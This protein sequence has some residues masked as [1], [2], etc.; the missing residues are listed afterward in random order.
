MTQTPIELLK[1]LGEAI[2][3]ISG[4]VD[5]PIARRKLN[6]DPNSEV[7]QIFRDA[8]AAWRKAE[9]GLE[10]AELERVLPPPLALMWHGKD[11][12]DNWRYCSPL[13]YNRAEAETIFTET[14]IIELYSREFVES[15][16][17]KFAIHAAA[18]HDSLSAVDEYKR[19]AESAEHKERVALNTL[20]NAREQYRTNN[21]HFVD[22]ELAAKQLCTQG[23]TGSCKAREH[24]VASECVSILSQHDI[25]SLTKED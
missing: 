10:V 25:D 11:E 8:V 15:L 17:D 23:C 9:Q 13:G 18:A 6:L 12:V 21:G 4:Y 20:Y 14:G 1:K 7:V 2:E 5:T 3:T 22:W 19:R 24:G 16:F